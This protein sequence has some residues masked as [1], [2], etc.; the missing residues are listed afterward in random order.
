MRVACWP[1]SRDLAV[2]LDG[3]TRGAVHHPCARACSSRVTNPLEMGS[4]EKSVQKI[5]K[6]PLDPPF[7]WDLTSVVIR[8]YVFQLLGAALKV[9]SK[10]SFVGFQLVQTKVGQAPTKLTAFLIKKRQKS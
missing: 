5:I 3:H 2:L 9:K 1:C 6:K 4:N 7:L 8:L 10:F